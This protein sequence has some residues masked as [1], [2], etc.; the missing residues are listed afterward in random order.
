MISTLPVLPSG[1][2]SGLLGEGVSSLAFLPG[3]VGSSGSWT[4][5]LLGECASF[6][7]GSTVAEVQGARDGSS[8]DASPAIVDTSLYSARFWSASCSVPSAGSGLAVAADG[9]YNV[10]LVRLLPSESDEANRFRALRTICTAHSRVTA[11]ST[12]AL[13]NDIGGES[14]FL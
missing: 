8:T 2:L 11:L 7:D 9:D 13:P 6:P 1:G 10:R 14:T 4:A 5:L 12:V 3:I